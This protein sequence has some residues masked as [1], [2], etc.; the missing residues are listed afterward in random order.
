[1]KLKTMLA[2]ALAGATVATGL[3]ASGAAAQT[4]T[5]AFLCYSKLQ[6]DPGSWALTS[7]NSANHTA[8]SLLAFGYWSPYA[9]TSVPTATK[10]SGGYYLI[11]NL[12]AN[13]TAV[14]GTMISQKGATITNPSFAGQPG[15][16]PLA[17]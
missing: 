10:I 2:T 3:A 13:M 17:H 9:E 11:C 16:Y 4:T 6:V 8:A 15:Y 14:A 1:M 12:P 7:T 5:A